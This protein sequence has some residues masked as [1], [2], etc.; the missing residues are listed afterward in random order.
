MLSVFHLILAAADE[1]SDSIFSPSMFLWL[2][3]II[4]LSYFLLL[5]TRRRV[6][7]SQQFS[8]LSANE[9]I[10]HFRK[11]DSSHIQVQIEELMAELA[12]LSREING[13]IDTR[14]AKLNALRD[15]ADR[16]IARF[17]Q[18]VGHPEGSSSRRKTSHDRIQQQNRNNLTAADHVARTK[19][20]PD[21]QTQAILDMAH[22]GKT[23]VSIAQKLGRP[24]GE[25][26]LILALNKK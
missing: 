4:F 17:E 22:Q 11:A 25:I 20:V 5:K 19:K 13:Q 18:T 21:P 10:E 26:E 12:D 3:I 2:G 15:E 8:H 23:V 6:R 14:L 9:R 7:R 16:T 24:V 1:A